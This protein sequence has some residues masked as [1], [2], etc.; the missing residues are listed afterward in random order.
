MLA[1]HHLRPMLEQAEKDG[2]MQGEV[3]LVP[4]ANPIGLAQRLDHK[5]MGRFELDTSENFNRHYPDF[6]SAVWPHIEGKL[7]QDP[8]QNVQLVRAAVQAF[9]DQWQPATELQSLRKCLV[10]LAF[11]ADVVLDLHCD[12][13]AVLHL[14]TESPCW[15]QMEPL[16]RLLG[17]QAVLLAKDSGG[18][19]FDECLSGL[20]WKLGAKVAEM[21][22]EIPIAQACLTTT[23]ELRGEADVTHELASSDA[24]ALFKF[25]QHA[26]VLRGDAP[27]LPPMKCHATP[28]AGSQTVRAP[29]PGVVVFAVDVGAHLNV[30]DLV[31][32]IIDPI[33]NTVCSVRAEVSGVMYARLNDRYALAND[34][35]ANIAGSK[36]FRTGYLLS[37]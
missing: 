23:V 5:P 37:A 34:D 22:P 6:C 28:L 1:A 8:V 29:V 3:I 25:L 12:C 27:Q 35:L 18:L 31:A 13:E 2:L 14:Y 33:A 36:P 26:K 24:L 10:S 21:R 15:P 30:G 16:A 4:V 11:D 17:A 9:I 19:S 7:G 20:W 32:E